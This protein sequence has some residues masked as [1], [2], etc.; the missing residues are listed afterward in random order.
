MIPGA[1]SADDPAIT[2]APKGGWTHEI[3]DKVA[4]EVGGRAR[5]TRL[6]MR[7][8]TCPCGPF[9]VYLREEPDGGQDDR[10]RQA[11]DRQGDATRRACADGGAWAFGL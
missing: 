11:E 6:R 10:D 4:Q 7:L 9:A 3:A 2:K 1:V 8:F 5:G